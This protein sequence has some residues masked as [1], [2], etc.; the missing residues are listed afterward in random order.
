MELRNA[1]KYNKSMEQ[2]LQEGCEIKM[3][4]PGGKILQGMKCLYF[5]LIN[6]FL[7]KN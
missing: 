6:F 1:W 2:D 3:Y 5:R 7:E 4:M